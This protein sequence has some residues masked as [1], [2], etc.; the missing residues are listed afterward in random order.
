MAHYLQYNFYIIHCH[1]KC[2]YMYVCASQCG[3]GGEGAVTCSQ[4]TPPPPPNQTGR[5]IY[6][7]RGMRKMSPKYVVGLFLVI[8]I[9]P[10]NII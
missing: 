10:Q 3:C 7:L 1:I 9:N 2:M 4:L 5:T 8:Y 6:F